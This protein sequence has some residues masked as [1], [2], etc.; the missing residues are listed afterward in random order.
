MDA[1]RPYFK[2]IEDDKGFYEGLAMKK[3]EATEQRWRDFADAASDWFWET[4]AAGR[5]VWFSNSGRAVDWLYGK[6]RED[7]GVPVANPADWQQL[8]TLTAQCKPFRN[9][10]FL[11]HGPDGFCWIRSSGVPVFDTDGQ[12]QGYRGTGTDITQTK[13]AQITAQQTQQ[14]LLTAIEAMPDMFAM[15]DADERLVLFNSRFQTAYHP[16]EVYQ[17]QAYREVLRALLQQQ[18]LFEAVGREARWYRQR[19]RRFRTAEPIFE[20]QYGADLWLEIR[21]QR[22]PDGGLVVIGTDIT[23]RKQA[24]QIRQRKQAA[25]AAQSELLRAILENLDEGVTV[26]DQ[27][28]RL[29]TWNQ[30]YLDLMGIPETAIRVGKS[31]SEF[32]RDD[33]NESVQIN[34]AEPYQL[35]VQPGGRSIEIRRVAMSGGFMISGFIVSTY[36]DVTRFKQ[37]EQRIRNSEQSFAAILENSQH[38]CFIQRDWR[39]LYVNDAFVKM[40]KYESREELLALNSLEAFIAPIHVDRMWDYSQKRQRLEQSEDDDIPSEYEYEAVCKDGTLIPLQQAVSIINWEGEA[41]FF[42]SVVDMT[43]HKETERKLI[44]ARRHTEQ[45]ARMKSDFL[46][47]MSHEIRTP[48]HGVLGTTELLLRTHLHKQQRHHVE[49]IARSGETLLRLIDD[50]LDISKIEAGKLTLVKTPFDLRQMLEDSM[51]LFTQNAARNNLA[52]QLDIPANLPTRL[53]GDALRIRQIILNLLSNAIKFTE[54]GEVK[55]TVRQL[56]SDSRQVWLRFAI[57]DTGIGIAGNEVPL[58]FDYFSQLDSSPA[59]RYGGA[60]LGLAISKKLAELMGGEIGVQTSVGQGSEFWFELPL[61]VLTAQEQHCLPGVIPSA[62]EAGKVVLTSSSSALA[63]QTGA[64]L[65]I[66]VAED[67]PVNQELVQA[68]LQGMG[69]QCQLADNG[70]DALRLLTQ[71]SFDMVLMDCQMP[72]M[73]GFTATREIRRREE[74]QKAATVIPIIAL[75][76]SVFKED[77]VRC[78]TVGMNDFLAKPFTRKTLRQIIQRWQR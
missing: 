7:I 14:Q 74:E 20:A 56:R 65:K 73:D 45:V 1:T 39:L 51:T 59:R 49:V 76:A 15:Y 38:G 42:C 60:G 29:V 52:L 16:V 36:S 22:M 75:T 26:L 57:S 10:E 41:A 24:E 62:D 61:G 46:A 33:L 9:M 72:V 66:L 70:E 5:Y 21:Q 18:L 47:N 31:Y 58:L 67:N 43:A 54:Q 35:L 12:F 34:S 32:C 78:Q 23:A 69:H 44:E 28:Q 71:H 25:L 37:A 64:S 68:M 27:Q 19:L 77:Q 2:A 8:Q 11:R 63:P 3:N 13:Q 40:L 48:L 17:G 53:N 30:R 4:D 55:C 6:T 50:I